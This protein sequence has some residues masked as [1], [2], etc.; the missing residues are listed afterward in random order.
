MRTA[1]ELLRAPAVLVALT[2]MGGLAAIALFAPSLAGGAGT[3]IPFG[4]NQIALEER[5]LPPGGNHLLGTDDLGRDVLARMIHGAR[6]SLTVGIVATLVAAVIGSILGA[7]AGYF[8]GMADWMVSRLIEV[9]LC[10][11]FLFLVLGLVALFRPSLW[12][13][14]IALGLT[15]WTSEARFLRG[16]LL[17]LREVDFAE[18]ARAAGAGRLRIVFLHLLPNALAPVIVS[19]TFGVG[20][21]ILSESALSFLGLGVPLPTASWGGILAS[22]HEH[23][24]YAWWLV[25]F[26]GLAIFATVLS[27]N[28]VGERLRLVL[29]PRTG[30][31]GV[32]LQ[33]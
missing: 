25:L 11:P 13:M 14:V 27:F 33:E 2:W 29:D 4:P 12:T 19:A 8:G 32:S 6:V 24:E 23:V 16:E 18:S 26:P 17:R 31:P 21:A 9:M 3:P 22:A 7:I 10:F 1:R 28:A 5:L 30:G 20:A 15:S